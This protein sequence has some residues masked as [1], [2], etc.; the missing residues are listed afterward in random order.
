MALSS[1]NSRERWFFLFIATLSQVS[2]AVIHLGIPALIPLIQDELKLSRMEMGF[3]VDHSNSYRP[4]WIGLAGLILVAL[5]VLRCV[6]EEDKY[7]L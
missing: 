5:S 4:A 6:R 1:Q 3:I 2:M 7:S